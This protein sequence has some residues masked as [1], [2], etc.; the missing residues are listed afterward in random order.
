MSALKPEWVRKVYGEAEELEAKLDSLDAFL[1]GEE[2][3]KLTPTYQGFL[4]EQKEAMK[5]YYLI[6]MWRLL[7]HMK[8]KVRESESD[9]KG[10][11]K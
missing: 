10:E 4:K 9:T 2:F 5:S 7:E 3:E 1:M 6:L 11:T 8:D